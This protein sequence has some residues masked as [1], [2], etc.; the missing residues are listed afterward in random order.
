[1]RDD[2]LDAYA[3]VDWAV[4]QLPAFE[5][6]LK[7]WF[8]APPF[9][10]VEEPHE[11]MGQKLFKLEINCPFPLTLNAAAGAIINSVRTSLDLLAASLAKR[12]GKTPH[13]DRHFP[14]YASHQCFIDPM[15]AAKR[16]KWLSESERQI[17][18]DL[19]PYDGGNNLLFAL[20][21]LDITR[22]HER[23]LAVHLPLTSA[24]VSPEAW[25]QGFGTPPQWPGF[26]D[27][28]VIAWTSINATDCDF[29]FTTEVSFDEGGAVRNK[30]VVA[31]LRQFAG[32]AEGIIQRFERT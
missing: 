6:A 26:E 17:I 11:K 28:A 27:G 9:L 3:A 29:H 32:L 2:L 15:N 1:M 22:K 23:L 21:H 20:H 18:K 30:P 16:E 4:S 24:I 8:D 12:N 7:A 31:T 5:Q 19:E 10:L 13:S 25:A 14:I